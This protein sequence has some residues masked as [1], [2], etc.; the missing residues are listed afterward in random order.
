[1]VGT[2]TSVQDQQRG[3]RK[4]LVDILLLPEDS[5]II[6][7][8]EN[9]TIEMVNDV[10]MLTDFD[11]DLLQYVKNNT[12]SDVQEK[13]TLTRGHLGW[14]RVLI[15]FINYLDFPS[16]SQ[17]EEITINIF[18][19]YRFR[20]YNPNGNDKPINPSESK[21]NRNEGEYFK[22]GTKRDK[23]QYPLLKYD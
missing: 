11:I 2:R 6:Q 7:A 22:K 4:L 9:E 3:F 10:L 16:E 23:S 5:P 8:F 21:I 14:I 13:E 19:K 20:I 12:K 18:N 15:A 17:L 1:M